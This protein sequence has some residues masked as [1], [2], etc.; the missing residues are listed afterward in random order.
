MANNY[1]SGHHR[2]LSV[3]RRGCFVLEDKQQ[4]SVVK[5]GASS[6]CDCKSPNHR[7]EKTN[8][9]ERKTARRQKIFKSDDWY[10]RAALSMAIKRQSVTS[11]G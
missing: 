8:G 6:K 9:V 2:R 3:E 5:D 4:C 7:S 10:E 11:G 1:S